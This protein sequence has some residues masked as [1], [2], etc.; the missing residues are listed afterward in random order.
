MSLESVHD[1]KCV[2]TGAAGFVGSHLVDALVKEGAH[3]V[4]LDVP[5]AAQWSVIP[6]TVEKIECDIRDRTIVNEAVAGADALFHLAAKVSV[7]GSIEDPVLYHETNVDG[8]LALLEAIRTTA[9]R[10]RMVLASSA[11]VYGDQPARA[12]ETMSARPQSPYALHKYF[13]ERMAQLWSS[14][15]AIETVSIR[16]FNIYGPRMNPEGPYAGVIGRFLKMKQEGKPLQITGDG[17]QTRDF[18]HVEDVVSAY[19]KAVTSP[20][21]GKGEVINIASGKSVT[22]ND[23]AGMIGGAVEYVSAR[24]EIHTSEASIERAR[25]LLSWE[26]AVA[27][28]D[29]ISELTARG[30]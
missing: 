7:P 18:V 22:V 20:M 8:T 23:L 15:Y 10:A 11:A 1:K 25:E 24:V 29:G 9:P 16:P 2:V 5:L 13:N 12:V 6:H 4:A 30:I 28:G 17:T 27:L 19:L 3:V 26:P 21:V 14:L